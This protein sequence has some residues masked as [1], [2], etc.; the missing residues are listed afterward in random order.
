[1]KINKENYEIYFLDYFEKRLQPRQIA[2]LLVFLEENPDLKAEFELFE[3]T[4]LIPDRNIRFRQ[5]DKLKKKEIIPTDMINLNNY[6]EFLVADLEGDLTDEDKPELTAFLELNPQLKLEYNFFRSTFLK[7][8]K[9]VEFAGKSSLKKVGLFV[10][11]RTQIKYAVSIAAAGILFFGLYFGFQE[12][13]GHKMTSV[14][15]NPEI[16]QIEK[17]IPEFKQD[18]QRLAYIQPKGR[19]KIKTVSEENTG[20]E[21]LSGRQEETIVKISLIKIDP[22]KIKDNQ[23]TQNEYILTRMSDSNSLFASNPNP[24]N[25]NKLSIE[26]KRPSFVVRFLENAAGKLFNPDKKEKKS[27]LEYTIDG[28]NLMADKSVEVE[29]ELDENGKVVAYQ[30]N[31]ENISISRKNKSQPKD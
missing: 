22:V 24:G 6:E 13:S 5:K 9:A 17:R 10:V 26:K 7:P 15:G 1:M 27:F 16:H 12:K 25:Q 29:K 23:E 18:D 19:I 3:K 30:L 11:Y 28:Y 21:D 14:R 4:A 8:E 31:G 20:A 2:E